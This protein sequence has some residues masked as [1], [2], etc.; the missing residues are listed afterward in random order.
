MQARPLPC[1]PPGKKNN[2]KKLQIQSN[3]YFLSTEKQ[4][5]WALSPPRAQSCVLARPEACRLPSVGKR[6][7]WA[8][9][10]RQPS[11]RPAAGREWIKTCIKQRI[12]S[13]QSYENWPASW[14]GAKKPA[15]ING[16]SPGLSRAALIRRLSPG[17]CGIVHRPPEQMEPE[18]LHSSCSCQPLL[19]FYLAQ[20][21]PSVVFKTFRPLPDSSL[22][23]FFF[24]KKKRF[25]IHVA[26]NRSGNR[27]SIA[28]KNHNL[29]S[30]R[31]SGPGRGGRKQRPPRATSHLPPAHTAGGA[32]GLSLALGCPAAGHRSRPSP[33]GTGTSA[34]PSAGASPLARCWLLLPGWY[35]SGFTLPQAVE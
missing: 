16:S 30:A 13:E 2:K 9:R 12:C 10:G 25:D 7:Q 18:V 32:A 24:L 8:E 14:E 22:S 6:L 33:R 5:N 1:Q 3:L 19:G 23:L 21:R 15:V 17:P 28:A 20:E 11:P 34:A 29:S 27:H 35:K 26:G 4:R 31:M